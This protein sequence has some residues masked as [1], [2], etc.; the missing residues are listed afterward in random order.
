MPCSA[1]NSSKNFFAGRTPS[2][3][4][5]LQPLADAFLHIGVGGNVE[6]ALV[7]RGILHD[8]RLKVVSD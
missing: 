5:I 6:H 3:F 1:S 2:F 4:R 8:S 7:G